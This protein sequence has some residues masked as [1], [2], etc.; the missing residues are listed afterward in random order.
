MVIDPERALA[1]AYAPAAARPALAALW[2]LDERLGTTVA[3][4]REAMI[5]R[6]RLAWWREALERLDTHAPPAEPLL[7]TIAA[8]ILP[9][10]VSGADLALLEAGWAALVDGDT[11]DAAAMAAHGAERGAPLFALAATILAPP[12]DMAAVRAA[13]A[14]WALADLGHRLRD[15]AA[16]ATARGLALRELAA[17]PRRWPSPLRPLGALTLLARADAAAETRAQGAPRRLARMAL[18]RLTGR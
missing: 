13:G 16:R 12:A 2:A 4:T 11:P 8:T 6:I 5:G 17:A 7:A 9:R 15:P 14:G 10:G 18:H 1:V 3:S